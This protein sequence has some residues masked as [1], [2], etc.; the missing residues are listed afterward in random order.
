MGICTNGLLLLKP[1][2]LARLVAAGLTTVNLSFHAHLEGEARALA[3]VGAYG[4]RVSEAAEL[5]LARDDVRCVF[6]RI[7]LASTLETVLDWV[8]WVVARARPGHRPLLAF[9]LPT[10][11]GRMSAS[12]NDFPPLERLR[13]ILAEALSIAEA[14]GH[15]VSLGPGPACLYSARPDIALSLQTQTLRANTISGRTEPL[16]YDGETRFGERCAR[17]AA[18]EDG[19]G[20]LPVTYF[21]RDPAAAEAWLSPWP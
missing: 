18:R 2:Y 6:F 5:L 20:G 13:P 14:H 7:L 15:E 10:V 16:H 17:C 11:R 1:G 3:A 21:T 8:R 9:G 12:S 19:C 4:G